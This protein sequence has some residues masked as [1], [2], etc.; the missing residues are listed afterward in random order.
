MAK[1]YKKNASGRMVWVWYQQYWA[2]Q[3]IAIA[4]AIIGWL[5]WFVE[6]TLFR[7]GINLISVLNPIVWGCIGFG[8]F[9]FV[10]LTSVRCF[11]FWMKLR[12]LGRWNDYKTEQQAIKS[13]ERGLLSAGLVRKT[14]SE[15]MVDVPTCDII[16]DD[17][18]TVLR[19]EK[20]P[21]VS[22]IASVAD[23][24]NSSL[25]KGKFADY[26][27]SEPIQTPDGLFY[28]FELDDVNRDLTFYPKEIEELVP[29]DPY[30]IRLMDD[31]YWS[32]STQPH[33]ILSGLTGS[34]KTTTALSILAQALGAGADV[35]I[36]DYKR[37]LSGFKTILGVKNVVECPDEILNLLGDLVEKMDQR[38]EY[39][40][41]KITSEG[42]LG[43]SG[44]DL[45]LRPVFIFCEE[46][47]A[48]S[49]AFEAK[50]RKLFH[51]YLKQIAMVGRACLYELVVMVQVATVESVPAGIKSNTNLKIL[52]GKSTSEMVTQVFSGGYADQVTNNPGKFRGWFFLNGETTKPNLF[53]VPNLHQA[54]LN[55]I[56]VYRKLYEIGKN[57]V[58]NEVL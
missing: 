8:L 44:E 19:V 49:E 27:V 36:L 42:V 29:A 2:W 48:L 37:E 22:D 25:R 55:S 34:F 17:C 3:M 47:G 7:I 45:K 28:V 38:N 43:L 41:A 46:L 35:Y 54:D 52:L 32:Y 58:F 12:Y 51:G 5:V 50:E 23:A 6:D 24:V 9:I 21:S 31:L 33:A 20:L 11:K 26:A 16:A 15:A 18:R 30:K 53:F 40:G 57:R 4:V 39:I 13:I 10:V 56:E 14:V 1:T